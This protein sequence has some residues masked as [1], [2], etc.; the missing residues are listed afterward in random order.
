M[1]LPHRIDIGEAAFPGTGSGRA[2]NGGMK[3]RAVQ[4]AEGAHR[5]YVR[6]YPRVQ[7]AVERMAIAEDRSFVEVIDAVDLRERVMN[8]QPTA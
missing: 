7:E 1:E 5:T 6:A 8:G 3:C 2:C 4:A